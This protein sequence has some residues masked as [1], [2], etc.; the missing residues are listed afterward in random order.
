MHKDNYKPIISIVIPVYNEA[1]KTIRCF[2]SIRA[3]TKTPYEIIWVDNGTSDMNFPHIKKAATRSGMHTKLVKF[4]RNLGFV[5]GTN[6]GIKEIEDTTKIIIFL[7]ND[8][9]VTTGWELGLVEELQDPNI[10]AVGPITQSKISWQ[11]AE[12]MNRRFKLKLPK[13]G[14]KFTKGVDTKQLERYAAQLTK[15]KGLS[16]DCGDIPLSFFCAAFRSDVIEKVGLLDEAFGFGLGDDDEYC[17]RLR[18]YGYK[19]SVR[20]DSFVF[21]HHRTTFKSLKLPVD[22]IRRMNIKILKNKKKENAQRAEE[23]QQAAS[24]STRLP[25]IP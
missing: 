10:G 1:D 5:R 15:N 21:H 23:R 7:N 14:V 12:N 22:S 20:L 19:L 24:I 17:H 25:C 3:C 13:F 8:T 18:S 2:S 4:N 16:V 9:V 6:A 11:E